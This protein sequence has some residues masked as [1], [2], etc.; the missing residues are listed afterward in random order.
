MANTFTLDPLGSCSSGDF[1][2]SADHPLANISG[3]LTERQLRRFPAINIEDSARTLTKRVV[4][5]SSVSKR[6][7]RPR[8]GNQACSASCGVG[9]GF[10][11]A[12]ALPA[13]AG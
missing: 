3:P 6:D 5:A 12:A 9:I 7:N 8:H 11:S 10:C 2:M 13:A 4:M 1:V